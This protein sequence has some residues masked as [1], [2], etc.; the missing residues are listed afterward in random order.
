MKIVDL[1]LLKKEDFTIKM[2]TGE[3]YTIDGNFTTEFYLDLYDSYQKVN[4]LVKDDIHSA[5]KLLKE[6]VVKILSLDVN[7]EVTTETLKKHKIDNFEML[8]SVLIAAMEQ[9]NEVT[10]D[11]NS[12]SPTSK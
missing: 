8:Q 11:P 9:A 1:S 3:E 6:I 4:D 10:S 7:K 5:V 12:K 2:P